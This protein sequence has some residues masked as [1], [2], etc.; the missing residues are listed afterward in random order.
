MA[1]SSP[2]AYYDGIDSDAC[3]LQLINILTLGSPSGKGG[4]FPNG[5]TGA[6]TTPAGFNA[7]D[8]GTKAFEKAIASGQARRLH[9][10]IACH[11][12][13]CQANNSL[14]SCAPC[15]PDK[16]KSKRKR[17]RLLRNLEQLWFC[18]GY[19]MSSACN[20]DTL[21]SERRLPGL[22]AESLPKNSH[23]CQPGLGIA[24]CVYRSRSCRFP[25]Q[26]LVLLQPPCMQALRRA[27]CA[28]GRR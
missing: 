27:R 18:L 9:Q 4:F 25:K 26:A 14:L 8:P 15:R 12:P 21:H 7:S 19:E 16:Q 10:S 11:M 28:I 5:L 2:K 22:I 3:C 23:L 1:A 24:A 17:Q 6:I 20:L 13:H